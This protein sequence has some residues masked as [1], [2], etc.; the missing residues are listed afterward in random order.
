MK[1]QNLVTVII[2]TYNYAHYIQEAIDSVLNS[3]FPQ[4]EI[5]IIVIDDGSKDNT[6]DIVAAYGSRVKYIFQDNAG[7]A[8]ATKVGINH[9]QGKY[10]F[11]LDADDLFLP[12][13][14]SEVVKIFESDPEMVHVAHPAICWQVEKDVKTPE[15]LP[16]NILGHKL[17]GRELLRFFYTRNILFG[18][19]STFAGRREALRKFSIPK[20]VDMYIDEYLVMCTLNQG[21]SYFIN[22]P[23]SIW[24]IHGNN[25]SDAFDPSVYEVKMRRSFNSIEAVLNNL[26]GFDQYIFSLYYLKLKI[27]NIA[28]KEKLN[29]KKF[30]DIVDMWLFFITHF[31]FLS[32]DYLR[33]IKAYTLLNR[34]VPTSAL[35]VMKQMKARF[36]I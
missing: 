34:S 12:N 30:S 10:I 31:N 29:N 9:S 32:K 2:P 22:S 26:E 7:K 6:F 14:I 24:R 16:Q 21:Y 19:G 11:N 23:L 1:P 27:F 33:V 28:V 5:E 17:Y 18:G 36:T 20:Q 13:K 35:N 4:E 15:L 8:W 25:F 3:N